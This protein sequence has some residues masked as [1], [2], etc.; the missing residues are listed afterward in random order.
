M[1][2]KKTMN[3]IEAAKEILSNQNNPMTL[4]QTYYQ[5]VS[6]QII[7]NN[8]NEYQR[9]SSALVWAR[10]QGI[11]K[12][13]WIED[14][15]RQPKKVSMWLNLA[16]F[17]DTVKRSY[18]K[19]IWVNQKNYIIVWLEKDAL[20]GIFFRIT[21]RYGVMLVVGKGYCYRQC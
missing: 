3:L 19:D 17:F 20:S 10:K 11:I 7:E 8:K 21:R 12:W 18:R 2:H 5:L 4:R 13:E 9:L 1:K 14:R 6:K 15:T 16:D